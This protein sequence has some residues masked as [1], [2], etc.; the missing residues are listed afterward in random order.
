MDLDPRGDVD[1]LI[2][3]IGNALI[4]LLPPD[5]ESAMLD[6]TAR[7]GGTVHSITNPHRRAEAT[8]VTASPELA[9]L[10]RDLLATFARHHRPWTRAR[11]TVTQTADGVWDYA[12]DFDFG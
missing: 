4:D 9:Q 1:P 12:A 2:G 3:R 7:P 10:T 8:W 6:V 5:W 11:I